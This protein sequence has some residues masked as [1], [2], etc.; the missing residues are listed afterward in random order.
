M[1]SW[2]PAALAGVKTAAVSV[3]VPF[4]WLPPMRLTLQVTEGA[5]ALA[6]SLVH[7]QT[8]TQPQLSCMVTRLVL[9]LS[10]LSACEAPRGVC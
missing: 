2:L 10:Y 1:Y 3:A 6:P 5:C 4:A 9:S 7:D 8:S